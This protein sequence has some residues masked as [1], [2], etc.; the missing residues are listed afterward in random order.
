MELNYC[1]SFCNLEGF[2]RVHSVT[3]C[4]CVIKAMLVQLLE[5]AFMYK[6]KGLF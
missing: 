6:G 5:F 3:S 2:G 1:S 4:K